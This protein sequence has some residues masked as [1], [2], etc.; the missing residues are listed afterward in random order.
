MTTRSTRQRI[1][2][3]TIDQYRTAAKSRIIKRN[4]KI[5]TRLSESSTNYRQLL[6]FCYFI[7]Q[8]TY[9]MRIRMNYY[10]QRTI[11][12]KQ[13]LLPTCRYFT[14]ET[15]TRTWLRVLQPTDV[16]SRERDFVA[17]HSDNAKASATIYLPAWNPRANSKSVG[18]AQREKT[19]CTRAQVTG[20]ALKK[21]TE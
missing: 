19:R 4:D 12:C 2:E 8:I 1:N 9:T 21:E 5:R 11:K 6:L 10:F 18:V 13:H 15:A 7:Q 14:N 17:R 3:Y 16:Y 20:Y